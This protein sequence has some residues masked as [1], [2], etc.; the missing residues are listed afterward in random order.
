MTAHVDVIL[1]YL[2][3][4]PGAT[5]RDLYPVTG[6]TPNNTSAT[7]SY[8]VNKTNKLE[9]QQV[10]VTLTNSPIYGYWLKGTMPNT[11]EKSGTVVQRQARPAVPK[12]Q[13][14]L[15]ALIAD[16][17]ESL[18]EQI[19]GRMAD[20]L[21][22][23]LTVELEDMRAPLIKAPQLN[24]PE[25]VETRLRQKKVL[26]VGLLP[27]QA[28]KVVDE[29]GEVFDLSFW[30]DEATA[31]LKARARAADLVVTFTSKIGHFAEDIIH[32]SGTPL[33]RCTGG[34]TTL[35]D[36]LTRMYVEGAQK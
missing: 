4:H 35:R 22:E 30:K 8:L 17:A 33:V 15:D 20:R 14:S 19:A 28:G 32:A 18:A 16:F 25:A 24:P 23:R 1:S 27:Q 31:L 36:D 7:L 9:R 5:T 29:F 6:Q 2:K 10:G 21:R 11:P 12:A 26:I 13:G 34:M 3:D